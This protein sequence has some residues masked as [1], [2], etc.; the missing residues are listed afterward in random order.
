M[1]TQSSMRCAP[2]DSW[3]RTAPTLLKLRRTASSACTSTRSQDCRA[4]ASRHRSAAFKP[5]CEAQRAHGKGAQ[6]PRSGAARN[7]RKPTGSPVVPGGCPRGDQP[8]PVRTASNSEPRRRAGSPARAFGDAVERQFPSI[9]RDRSKRTIERHVERFS[10]RRRSV[11]SPDAAAR[12]ARRLAARLRLAARWPDLDRLIRG[13]CRRQCAEMLATHRP[14][15][16]FN[17]GEGR[18]SDTAT[19]SASPAL[20]LR[21]GEASFAPRTDDRAARLLWRRPRSRRGCARCAA[22]IERSKARR[23]FFIRSMIASRDTSRGR[24]ARRMWRSRVNW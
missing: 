2:T 4:P 24:H 1:R 19:A 23:S 12:P 5:S 22:S 10:S 14:S 11:R 3:M 8:A 9:T 21:L 17:D 15:P 6:S 13:D 18:F 16:G 20:V 7:S